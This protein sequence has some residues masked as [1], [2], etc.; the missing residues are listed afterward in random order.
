MAD[1]C[2]DRYLDGP[3]AWGR[4]DCCL[5]VCNALAARGFGDPAAAFRGLYAD[6]DGATAAAGGDVEAVAARVCAARGW[7]EIDPAE[8][9]DNDIGVLRGCL[10]IRDGGWWKSKT[11]RGVLVSR[12]RPARVWRPQRHS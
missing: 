5:S 4:N 11:E 6:Q 1:V 3:F 7:P 12:R 2:I 8:A 9:R 10:A